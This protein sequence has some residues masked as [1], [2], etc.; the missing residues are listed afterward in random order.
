MSTSLTVEQ[1]GHVY[2]K[3]TQFLTPPR[4]VVDPDGIRHD[5]AFALVEADD[6]FINSAQHQ[7]FI[8]LRF[9]FDAASTTLVLTLPDGRRLAGPAVG[10]GRRF[11]IDHAGLRAIEVAEVGGPWADALSAH[12][13]RPIRLVRCLSKGAAI[14]VFAV[15]FIT[16]GSLR[17]LAREVGAPVDPTRFRA[18]FIL[19]NQAEHEEDTWDGRLL[20][21]GSAL[22]KVRTAVPRCAITG[23]NPLSG[24][25]D[26]DVMKG[27][28]KYREKVSLPDGMLPGY[29]TPGFAT[30]AEV[31]EAGEVR[32]GDEA[33]LLT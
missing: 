13:G 8:P 7:T 26:Q 3:G 11:S 27:L 31:I 9:D 25:R 19:E 29:A 24:A 16:T 6:K 30:Y 20:R 1:V 18:G 22:F 21:I 28:I 4:V 17:R 5:R 15:T 23:F 14:D 32:V 12:A 2:V 33:V 10:D